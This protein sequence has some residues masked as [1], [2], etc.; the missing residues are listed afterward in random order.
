MSA[1]RVA[2][3][4]A[5]RRLRRD[6]GRT[7]FLT[8]ALAVPLALAVALVSL[9][10]TGQFSDETR[11]RA[12]IGRSE[13]VVRSSTFVTE[14]GAGRALAEGP[15][16]VHRTVGRELGL[17]PEVDGR[18][19]VSAGGRQVDS[20]GYGVD[21]RHSVHEGRFTFRS[22]K[23]PSGA[24]EVALSQAVAERLGVGV[25]GR[26]AVGAA[27]EP[28]T[29]TGVAAIRT[30]TLRQFVLAMPATVAGLVPA[31]ESG[32]RAVSLS[33]ATVVVWHAT[34]P[35]A[36]AERTALT[37]AGWTA[38]PR[39]GFF[40]R[41]EEPDGSFLPAES[42]ATWIIGLAVL[43]LAEIGLIMGAV[44]GIVVRGNRRE[45]GLLAAAGAGPATRRAVITLQGL[46]TGVL[47]VT[48]A[49]G[50][51]LLLA[52]LL[53]PAVSAR[54][55]EIWGGLR[56]APVPTAV[57][58]LLGLATPALAARVAA[59]GIGGDVVAALRDQADPVGA[60]VR[61]GRAGLAVLVTA[62]V[63]LLGSGAALEAAVTVLLGALALVVATGLLARDLLPSTALRADRFRLSRRLGARL[64]GRAAGRSATMATVVAG[65]TL[66]TGLVLAAMG[67]LTAEVGKSYVP[68]APQGSL[69][70][71]ATR[72]PTAGTVAAAEEALGGERLIPLG[73]AVPPQPE[74]GP[75]GE[76]WTAWGQFEVAEPLP[77]RPPT[78]AV[79]AE[80]DLAGV[81][82]RPATV[83]ERRALDA[84]GAL[85]RDERLLSGDALTLTAP[86]TQS[87]G[88]DEPE[89]TEVTLP[90]VRAGERSTY[91]QLPA[92]FVTAAGL[93]AMGGVT[94][95][96]ETYLYLPPP[97]E[98][99]T[100]AQEDR[101]RGALAA[102]IG[103]ASFLLEVERGPVAAEVLRA[104]TLGGGLVLMLVAA[105]LAFLTV[106]LATQEM[107]PDLSTLA[108]VGADRRFRGRL[109]GVHAGQVTLLGVAMG[110][111]VTLLAA[112]ALLAALDVGWSLWPWFGLAGAA[113]GA[114]LAAV[115]AGRA[116]GARVTTL[117]RSSH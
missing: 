96:N 113:G 109:A 46:A 56:L 103:S 57:L 20:Y 4:I 7:V 68:A 55:G 88:S 31:P 59:R 98:P 17:E 12:L 51:G 23:A 104:T 82:G 102:D 36:D 26:V 25:G 29:V 54:Y 8:L 37:E 111:A 35:L 110:T 107:R 71:Y 97:A 93:E 53:I 106:T 85:V 90:A 80:R 74:P 112:P 16:V 62:G 3:R 21:L 5:L 30:D 14:H 41:N 100:S 43:V 84:G 32:G 72:M 27:S 38:E 33:D 44:Y 52:W 48:L 63:L 86:V 76:P 81:L 64:M 50:A 78:V 116:G 69:F 60:G 9:V 40:D 11:V 105:A 108:A 77:D 66:V 24:G 73:I 58:A 39:A 42:E 18:L 19:P 45:L 114:V 6:R 91:R 115:V 15:A 75:D 92:V 95:P 101:A 22:G 99:L 10:S 117:L 70:A 79:V 87:L 67:G 65:L 13:A 83:A 94:Q 47:A 1:R 61:K 49:V 34:G 89:M 28:A 2:A